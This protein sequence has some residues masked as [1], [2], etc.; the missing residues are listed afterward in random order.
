MAHR[1][2]VLEA[3][4]LHTDA[5]VL[6]RVPEALHPHVRACALAA[7]RA[8]EDKTVFHMRD[9]FRVWCAGGTKKDR[10]RVRACFEHLANGGLFARDCEVEEE[11]E[12]RRKPANARV[13]SR[14]RVRDFDVEGSDTGAGARRKG[15]ST[16]AL[17][18]DADRA[19]AAWQ[20]MAGVTEAFAEW[21]DAGDMR[22][23]NGAC[24]AAMRVPVDPKGP[25]DDDEG[26]GEAYCVCAACDTRLDRASRDVAAEM[27]G[28]IVAQCAVLDE[29]C[30]LQC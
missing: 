25:F 10:D 30:V 3:V 19:R 17:K 2:R 21:A 23:P 11:G 15:T 13:T 7:V 29:M 12:G 6:A 20:R 5:I 1:D 4:C 22:C 28:A 18:L 24:D 16:F 26:G 27:K 8:H 9:A 14:K